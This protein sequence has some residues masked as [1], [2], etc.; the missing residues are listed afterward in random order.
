LGGALR[1]ME[2]DQGWIRTLLDRSENDACT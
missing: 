1:H 2:S